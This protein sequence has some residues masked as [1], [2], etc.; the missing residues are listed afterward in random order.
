MKRYF[1]VPLV[2][3]YLLLTILLALFY[4][5]ISHANSSGASKQNT[6]SL[7]SYEQIKWLDARV[8]RDIP[9][10]GFIYQK[11]LIDGVKGKDIFACIDRLN[12]WLWSGEK[13]R[14]LKLSNQEINDFRLLDDYLGNRMMPYV[15]ALPK[16]DQSQFVRKLALFR[17]ENLSFIQSLINQGVSVTGVLLQEVNEA[18]GVWGSCSAYRI[19]LN[20]NIALYQNDKTLYEPMLE[21][22]GIYELPINVREELGTT[23]PY[24]KYRW[25]DMHHLADPTYNICPESIKRLARANPKLLNK[26]WRYDGATP[27]HLYLRGSFMQSSGDIQLVGTL[28]TSVNVN[29]RSNDGNTPLHDFIVNTNPTNVANIKRVIKMMIARGANINLKNNQGIT[30]KD[31]ILKRKDLTG[32]INKN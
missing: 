14:G 27:L 3:N 13:Y 7:L 25:E 8:A 30:V 2:S 21:A 20:K 11:V 12:S 24:Y 4:S 29:M 22:S 19:F 17:S 16:T 31:L 18:G 9:E 6:R 23:K 32:F 5:G 10:C 26:R 15:L 28:I 1:H